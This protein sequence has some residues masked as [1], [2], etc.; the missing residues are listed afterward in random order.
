MICPTGRHD[1]QRISD[2]LFPVHYGTIVHAS[3]IGSVSSSSVLSS[4]GRVRHY[5]RVQNASQL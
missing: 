3:T 4:S 2:I 5:T 1:R